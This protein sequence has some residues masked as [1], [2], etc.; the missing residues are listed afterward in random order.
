M[1]L[2]LLSCIGEVAQCRS[3]INL[4]EWVKYFRSLCVMRVLLWVERKSVCA[5]ARNVRFI[6]E[7]LM[8]HCEG[9]AA[10]EKRFRSSYS[11]V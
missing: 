8:L 2:C 11:V 4:H 6:N 10:F 7:F 3:R 9:F 5:N 1:D